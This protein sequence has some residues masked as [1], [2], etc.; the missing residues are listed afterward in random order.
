M[1]TGITAQLADDL[2]QKRLLLLRLHPAEFLLWDN[3][4]KI[5]P[6]HNTAKIFARMLKA[7]WAGEA[8][9]EPDSMDLGR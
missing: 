4:Y 9:D 1:V 8:T 7:T 3:V 5:V 2:Y 6:M